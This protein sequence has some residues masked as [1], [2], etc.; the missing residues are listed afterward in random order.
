[1]AR[2]KLG[3]SHSWNENYV[4]SVD[5]AF[6]LTHGDS[7]RVFIINGSFSLTLPAL[8]AGFSFKMINGATTQMGIAGGGSVIYYIGD[9]GADHATQTGRDIHHAVSA[10][11][12]NDGNINDV[13][14][15]FCDGTNWYIHG[16]TLATVD[17]S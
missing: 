1:M 14:D 15:V 3:A 16:R 8:K 2:A 5:A 11:V 6:T 4:E 9:Y 7:G 12:N 17:A 10:V 13:F